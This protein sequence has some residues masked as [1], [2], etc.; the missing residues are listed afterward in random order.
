MH[1]VFFGET[2]IL[3]NFKNLNKMNL[4]KL[5]LVELETY[6]KR[7]L[8]GGGDTFSG[9]ALPEKD[10]ERAGRALAYVAHQ[11]GDFFRGVWDGLK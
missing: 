8:N 11:V 4:Q 10:V 6:E 9:T 2:K 7:N 5:N 3:V 1:K